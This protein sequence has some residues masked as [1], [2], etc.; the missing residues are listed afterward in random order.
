MSGKVPGRLGEVSGG[1]GKFGGWGDTTTE[2]ASDRIKGLGGVGWGHRPSRGRG[3][4]PRPE[5]N[6]HRLQSESLSS[7]TWKINVLMCF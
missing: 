1:L 5:K 3:G 6:R 2:R 7:R 4:Q